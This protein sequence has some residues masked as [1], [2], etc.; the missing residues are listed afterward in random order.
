MKRINSYAVM[1]IK[2]TIKSALGKLF[3]AR[4]EIYR[5]LMDWEL[6]MNMLHHPSLSKDSLLSKI[7][8]LR[9]SCFMISYKQALDIVEEEVEVEETIKLRNPNAYK[10]LLVKK[11]MIEETAEGPKEFSQKFSYKKLAFVS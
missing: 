1:K 11:N 3:D 6:L 4:D 7:Q 8:E 5:S 2:K 10:N 9:Q